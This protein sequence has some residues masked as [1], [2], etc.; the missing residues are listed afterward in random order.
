MVVASIT[1]LDDDAWSEKHIENSIISCVDSHTCIST[2]VKGNSSSE[3]EEELEPC[4]M[5]GRRYPHQHV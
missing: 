3:E 5:C 4:T 1:V 2:T